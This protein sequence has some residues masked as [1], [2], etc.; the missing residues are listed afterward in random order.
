MRFVEISQTSV[1][2]PSIDIERN[3]Q[4]Y[5]EVSLCTFRWTEFKVGEI[6]ISLDLYTKLKIGLADW[7]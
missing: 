2:M 1:V 3:G 6:F 4:Q 5:G 7:A